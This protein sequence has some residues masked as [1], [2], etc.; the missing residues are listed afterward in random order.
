MRLHRFNTDT[1]QFLYFHG[2]FGSPNPRE[3]FQFLVRQPLHGRQGHI[4]F[5]GAA[6]QTIQWLTGHAW[7]E[8][9]L[10]LKD[11][12]HRMNQCFRL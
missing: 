4:R 10:P 1:Q 5:A 12:S 7:T 8:V 11:L 9:N 6:A 3:D 2:S